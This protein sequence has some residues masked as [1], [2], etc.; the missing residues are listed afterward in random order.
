MA[1]YM[2]QMIKDNASEI[3]RVVKVYHAYWIDE[4][5]PSLVEL[6]PPA[7]RL[8]WYDTIDWKAL[9]ETSE[10]LWAKLSADAKTLMDAEER[11]LLRLEP[12]INPI[13]TYQETAFEQQ[14]AFKA[15][16][17]PFGQLATAI[18][19]FVQGQNAPL[20]MGRPA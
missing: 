3:V 13:E 1:T 16:T 4:L 15:E 5:W 8:D 12:S 2:H 19:P 6:K 7:E 17:Q 9:R 11:W 20:P 10:L 14:R 18:E